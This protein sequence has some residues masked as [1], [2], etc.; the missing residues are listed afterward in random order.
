MAN[1]KILIICYKKKK[2]LLKTIL[3]VKVET[4]YFEKLKKK[5]EIIKK[6]SKNLNYF[7]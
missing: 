2:T 7:K 5:D 1:Y 6:V 4:V 3:L